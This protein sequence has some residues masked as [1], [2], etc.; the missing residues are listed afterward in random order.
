[1]CVCVRPMRSHSRRCIYVKTMYFFWYVYV[2]AI[3]RMH[4]RKYGVYM[5]MCTHVYICV[6]I[7]T[8]KCMYEMD[9]NFCIYICNYIYKQHASQAL[10]AH[11]S[12]PVYICM[13]ERKHIGSAHR[14]RIYTQLYIPDIPIFISLHTYIYTYMNT[15]IFKPDERVDHVHTNIHTHIDRRTHIHTSTNPNTHVYI[16]TRIRT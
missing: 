9:I 4:M 10:Y 12:L 1:M 14:P 7:G 11:A 5:C 16:H 13:I 8:F 15:Y 3:V 6:C 2:C